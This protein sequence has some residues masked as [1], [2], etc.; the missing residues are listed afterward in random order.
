LLVVLSTIGFTRERRGPNQDQSITP[1][2]LNGFEDSN[3]VSLRGKYIFYAMSAKT[4]ALLIRLDPMKVLNW[5]VENGWEDPGETIKG[6]PKLSHAYLLTHSP[7]LTLS[8][9]EVSK[10]TRGRPPRENAP[11]HLLHS[12]CHSLMA[13]ARRHTGYDTNSLMEYL[14]P[15]DLSFLVYVTSVQN[16]TSGGLLSLFK[17]YLQ[18][19]FD[20]ASIYA[21][22]CAFDPI[23]SDS[24]ASCSGCLQT[25]IGCE[26]FN[27]DISRAYLHG[28]NIDREQSFTIETGF[29]NAQQ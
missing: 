9:G 5:C 20:D 12:I 6:D 19:W 25:V 1:V 11:F 13:T 16:Y 10:Q 27:H 23:C 2:R 29:W 18:L 17:H 8:P 7:A 3:E 14:L 4:E 22:N 26:T 21:F 15:C 28:G 24:G